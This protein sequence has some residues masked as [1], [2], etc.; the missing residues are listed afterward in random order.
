[1]YITSFDTFRKEEMLI[2]RKL[3]IFMLTVFT[4]TGNTGKISTNIV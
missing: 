1:M 4:F 3:K 2:C